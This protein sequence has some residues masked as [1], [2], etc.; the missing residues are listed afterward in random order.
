MTEQP[1][2]GIPPATVAVDTSQIDMA[3]AKLN[4]LAEAAE[5]AQKAIAAIAGAKVEVGAEPKSSKWMG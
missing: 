3:T 2:A 4:E 1:E 5:R